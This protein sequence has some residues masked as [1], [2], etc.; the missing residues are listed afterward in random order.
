M[1]L[2]MRTQGRTAWVS[3][4]GEID[5]KETER[6]R[7]EVDQ[8]INGHGMDHLVFD[9][10]E[11]NFID[12]SGVGGIIGRYRKMKE[13]GGHM[14]IVGARPTVEKVLIF[15]GIQKIIPLYATQQDMPRM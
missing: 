9:L 11:V 15:S 10:T 2:E 7:Q 4:Q 8:Y 1:Q 3:I 14:S 13:L 12:S 5:L 6:L